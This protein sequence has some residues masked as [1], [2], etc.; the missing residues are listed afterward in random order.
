ML[1]KAN[2]DENRDELKREV[3]M[4]IANIIFG[5]AGEQTEFRQG[6]MKPTVTMA[7]PIN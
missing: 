3:M 4:A 1:I 5:L 7:E 2:K 6:K